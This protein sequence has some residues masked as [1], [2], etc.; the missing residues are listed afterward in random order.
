MINQAKYTAELIKTYRLQK[1]YSQRELSLLIGYSGKQGQI[2][3]NIESGKCQFPIDKIS[4][5]SKVLGMPINQIVK[6]MSLDYEFNINKR[7][8]ELSNET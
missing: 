5:L 4:I 2:I 3:S 6:N 8:K 1:R 7:I